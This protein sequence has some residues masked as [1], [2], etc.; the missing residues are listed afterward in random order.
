MGRRL[1]E[2]IRTT[3]SNRNLVLE[4]PALS[5]LHL[6]EL[7]ELFVRQ[8]LASLKANKGIGLETISARLLKSSA[9]TITP[10]ITMLLNLSINIRS[11]KF[12]NLWKCSKIAALFKSG[13]RTHAS[14]YRPIS[15]LPTISKIHL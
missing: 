5:Q 15:I 3:W 6:T 12:P 14:S 13:D 9:N 7:K 1:A 4:Q 10:S 11:D 8:Q 2:K